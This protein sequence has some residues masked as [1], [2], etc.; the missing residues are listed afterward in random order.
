MFVPVHQTGHALQPQRGAGGE[1]ARVVRDR[2]PPAA[3]QQGALCAARSRLDA[4]DHKLEPRPAQAEVQ[5][6]NPP[7]DTVVDAGDGGAHPRAVRVRHRGICQDHVLG[8]LPV[9][10]AVRCRVCR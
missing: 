7:G 5:G 3:R 2:V 4:G 8:L 9:H 10:A 1:E 6:R